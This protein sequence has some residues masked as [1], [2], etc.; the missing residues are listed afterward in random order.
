MY[1]PCIFFKAFSLEM[2]IQWAKLWVHLALFIHKT[3]TTT[4][5]LHKIIFFVVRKQLIPTVFLAS[6]DQARYHWT[7]IQLI[8]YLFQGVGILGG[9]RFPTLLSLFVQA[10]KR[11][12][13]ICLSGPLL[14]T[15]FFY[16][17][18]SIYQTGHLK[19]TYISET[20]QNASFELRDP[21]NAISQNLPQTFCN[22]HLIYTDRIC[23]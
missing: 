12:F 13:E 18:I 21:L 9:K 5:L 22:G 17:L 14:V 4:W 19:S 10:V 1:T 2:D 3:D 23:K 16:Y 7:K 11:T 6:I 8:R 15:R 20:V